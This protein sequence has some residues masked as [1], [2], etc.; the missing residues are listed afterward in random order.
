MSSRSPIGEPE[1]WSRDEAERLGVPVELIPGRGALNVQR[2]VGPE[3][4]HFTVLLDVGRI[5]LA[6]RAADPSLLEPLER[7]D[8]PE[9]WLTELR[10]RERHGA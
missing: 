7:P 10:L 9:D 1:R 6:H 5:R 2:T 4:G 8:W 3:G